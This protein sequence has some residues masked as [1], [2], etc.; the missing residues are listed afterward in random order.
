[1]LTFIPLLLQNLLLPM[2]YNFIRN[3][4]IN[5]LPNLNMLSDYFKIRKV[6]YKRYF[7]IGISISNICFSERLYQNECLG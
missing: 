4:F 3:R 5:S 1:M 2:P 7:M 6:K